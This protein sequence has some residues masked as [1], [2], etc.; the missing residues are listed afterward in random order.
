MNTMKEF[1]G[2]Q[3]L[4]MSRHNREG[5]PAKERSVGGLFYERALTFFI[6]DVNILGTFP[7]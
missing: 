3:V 2:N 1:N 4:R 6:W 5:Q 7:Y